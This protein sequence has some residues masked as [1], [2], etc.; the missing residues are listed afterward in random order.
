[1]GGSRANPRAGFFWP[2]ALFAA[3]YLVAS[4]AFAQSVPI[5][6]YVVVQPIDVCSSAGTGCAPY[7]TTSTVGNVTCTGSIASTTLTV[8]SCSSGT[9]RVPDT[10]SGTGIVAGT[11]ITANGTGTGGAGTYTVNI[12]QNVSSTTITAT[13]P[14]GFVVN[15]STGQAYPATGGID[16][17]R[18][19]LN[20]IGIDVSWNP[21]VRYNSATNP[22]PPLN[23]TAFQTLNVVQTTNS[24]GATIFQSQD[25]LALSQQNS[26]SQT[27]KVPS[28]PNFGVPVSSTPSV[29]NMFFVN[30]LNPPSTQSGSQLYDFSWVNNNG[31]SIGGNTFFPPFPLTPRI[32][33][34]AHAILHNLGLDHTTYGAGPWTPPPYMD[35]FGVLPPI[36]PS[37]VFGECDAGYPACMANLMSAGNLRTEPTLACVLAPS[38]V[39]ACSSKPTLANGMADQLTTQAETGLYPTLLP[40]SQQAAIFDPSGFLQPLANATTSLSVSPSGKSINVTLTGPAVGS[41]RPNETLLAWVLVLPPGLQFDSNFKKISQSPTR[42]NLLQDADFPYADAVDNAPGKVYQLGMLYDVCTASTA[43]CLIIEFNTPGAGTNNQ[44][45]FSKGLATATSNAQF[46]GVDVTYIFNDGSSTSSA[47]GP[48]PGGVVPSTLTASS[49]SPDLMASIPPQIVDQAAFTRAVAAAG[50]LPCNAESTGQCPDPVQ[51]GVEDANGAQEQ[52]ICYARG[53]PIQCPP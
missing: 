35:P 31:I 9:L 14:V 3:A 37:P 26:I 13:G 39:S 6:N 47:L 49:Q 23:P 42:P 44:I 40:K 12:S 1:M 8:A 7:N 21:I 30:K 53:V 41:G 51:T 38:T 20:Q 27:G 22:P 32:S 16:V 45:T 29:I 18:A 36:P 52:Q 43:Q 17:T 4:A 34:L 50:N 33:T 24:A 25:F 28:P 2:S 46:C 11:K 5:T 48:C 15:P 19:M 10:L